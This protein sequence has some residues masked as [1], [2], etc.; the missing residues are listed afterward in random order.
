MDAYKFAIEYFEDRLPHARKFVKGALFY[1]NEGD[2]KKSAFLLHQGIAQA[3]ATL[4][5]RADQL[6]PAVPQSQIPT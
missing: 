5:A 6:K 1:G 2:F 4:A 3:Y